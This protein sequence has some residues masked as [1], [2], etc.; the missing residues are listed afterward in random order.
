M[1]QKTTW[2]DGVSVANAEKL[3]NMENGI[4]T[5]SRDIEKLK[6]VNIMQI[7][8]QV[9]QTISGTNVNTIN[10]LLHISVGDKLQFENNGV[11]IGN[12][13]SKVK[14]SGN[15]FLD[16]KSGGSE[17]YMY[18]HISKNAE[19]VGHTITYSN[20]IFGSTPIPQK[21]ISV[22]E[23]DIITLG[24]ELN[25]GTAITRAGANSTWLYVEVVE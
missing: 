4:E 21:I 10:C 2:V 5:N 18:G 7:A 22:K 23:G 14:V 25:K 17:T 20:G 13:I 8:P 3:N 1:Y 12:G 6:D 11:K 19:D 9:S 16:Q 15:I 24:M